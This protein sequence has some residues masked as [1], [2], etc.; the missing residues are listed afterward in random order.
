M[1][2]KPTKYNKRH[3]TNTYWMN[4]CRPRAEKYNLIILQQNMDEFPKQD[5]N[6]Q[7]LHSNKLNF[8]K[9]KNFCGSMDTNLEK[10]LLVTFITKK[11]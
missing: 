2:L 6:V 4:T 10:T 1:T 7:T 5:T 9:M 11:N 3:S 8:I